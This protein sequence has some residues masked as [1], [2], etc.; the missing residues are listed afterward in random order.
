M[1]PDFIMA[2][3]FLGRPIEEEEEDLSEFDTL[4]LEF[5]DEVD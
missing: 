2:S 5:E 3:D 4:N 1:L